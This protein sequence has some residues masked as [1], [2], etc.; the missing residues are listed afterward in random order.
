M[1]A[2]FADRARGCIAMKDGASALRLLSQMLESGP[3]DQSEGDGAEGVAP[4]NEGPKLQPREARNAI[5]L[6]M[7]KAHL[8]KLSGYAYIRALHQFKKLGWIDESFTGAER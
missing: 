1:K 3:D 7:I 6:S 8:R 5:P 2:E 4:P